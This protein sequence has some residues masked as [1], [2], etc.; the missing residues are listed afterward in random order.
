MPLKIP[1]ALIDDIL[2]GKG[3]LFLGAGASREASFPDA[4]MLAEYLASKAG[5]SLSSKLSGQ[6]LD[7]VSDYLYLE[8]GYG[9]QWVRQKIIDCFEKKH[10]TVKRPPSIAHEIMTKIKW[11]AIFTTNYD[12][13]IEITYD[14]SQDAIQRVLPI[15]TPDEQI[16]RHEEEVTRLIKLNGSV[17]EAARNSSHELVITFADQQVARIRNQRFYELL[18]DEAA[19]GPI[20]FIGFSFTHPGAR[21]KGTSPEFSL[22]QEILR[23]M[24]PAARWHYCVTPFDPSSPSSELLCKKLRANQIKVINATFGEF[25]DALF[26]QLQV[27]KIP[28]AKRPPIL[29]PITSTAISIDA[30]EYAKDKRHFEI[31]GPHLEELTPPSVAESLN[32]YE[33]WSSFL[34]GHFVERFCKKDFLSKLKDCIH[35]APQIVPFVASPGWGKTFLLR[36]AAVAFYRESRPVIWLNPYG[37]VDIEMSEGTPIILGMWD[38]ARIDRIVSMIADEAKEKSLSKE[39]AVPIIIADNC[40][41]RVEEVFSLFRYLTNNNRS[42]VL[43]FAVRDNE[44]DSIIQDYP[45]LKTIDEFRPEGSYNTKDEV[46]A[47]IDF[48][49]QHKVATIEDSTQQEVV[50]QS[51]ISEEADT[52]IILALQVIFDRNHRPFSKIVKEFWEGLHEE[53]AQ[54]LVLRVAS[55]HRFGSAFFPR[56]Y[57]LLRTFPYYTHLQVLDVYRD[58]QD[59]HIL[60]ESSYDEEPCVYTLHSLVAEHITKVCGKTPAQIDDELILIVQQMEAWHDRDLEIIRR[61]LK[62]INAFNINLSSED[63]IIEL[64]KVAAETTNDD[65]VVC[66]QFSKYLVRRNEYESAFAM[67]DRALEKN[68]THPTLQHHKGYVLMRWGKSLKIDGESSEA[69]DKFKEARKYFALS[70]VRATSNVEYGYVSHLDMLLF[71]ISKAEDEVEKTNLI[72]E[73]AQL[74]KEGVREMPEHHLNIFLDDRFNY[75]DLDGKAVEELCLRIA[76]AIPEGKASVYA[77]TFL[78]QQLYKEERY[79]G[80]VRVLR[81]QR[82]MSNGGILTWVKEA[83]LHAR[84]GELFEASKCIDSAKRREQYAENV[85][86]IWGL[87][88]WNLVVAIALEDFKEAGMA[89]KRLSE[90]KFFPRDN[91][92]KGYIWKACA[93]QIKSQK[94]SF[95]KHAKIWGGRV[96]AARAGGRYASIRMSNIGGDFFDIYFNQ[97]YFSRKDMRPGDYVYFIITI[98][99]NGV[100]ADDP[101]TKPFVNTVDDIFVLD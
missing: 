36:E 45:L 59:K 94:R 39:E 31:I 67:A 54:K 20:I 25:L 27:T 7:T 8:S 52:A 87:F 96:Q 78:A 40:P 63:K 22:L 76:K 92:P 95:K 50:A 83:E 11:R 65:W 9:K 30:D 35:N 51:I 43:V 91:L 86:A 60:F 71:Q 14:S 90:S 4:N 66:D 100:R 37:T 44:F 34:N 82:Q 98:L 74:Y 58:L 33:T 29:I 12:R 69:A 13:L 84:E 81:M 46:R 42:F 61:L 10:K 19:N 28:L 26:E 49:T 48:C 57:T 85:E 41:E 6:P 55:L 70:R 79:K 17:D 72:A 32:G 101:A 3:T 56:L 18:R 15:Y 23:E 68:P 24:G 89:A 64:F 99:P 2:K 62:Q 38:V 73:G 47:L 80:A 93:K 77:A 16:R 53:V 97:K 88:Y 1:W 5:N 75:F 21:D